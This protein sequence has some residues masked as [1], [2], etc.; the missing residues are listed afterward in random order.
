[1]KPK[2]PTSVSTRRTHSPQTEHTIDKRGTV[3]GFLI[4]ITWIFFLWYPLAAALESED[5]I[6]IPS[7]SLTAIFLLLY[8]AS[9]AVSFKN[10]LHIKKSVSIGAVVLLV[11]GVAITLVQFYLLG[12]ISVT[13]IVYLVPMSVFSLPQPWNFYVGMLATIT[14]WIP[15]FITDIGLISV[16]FS[17]LGTYV[18]VSASIFFENTRLKKQEIVAESATLKERERVARDVHDVLGHTLTAIALKS[19]LA[20]ELIE[21]DPARAKNEIDAIYEL[22]RQAIA[23]VR[24][25]VS[26]LRVRQLVHELDSINTIAA[27]AG[28]ALAVEGSP[29]EVEP[30]ARIL[31]AWALREAATNTIRHASATRITVELTNDSIVIRDDGIGIGSRR[32][33]NGLTGLRQRVEDAGASISVTDSHPGTE[34]RINL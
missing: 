13:F 7:I 33:G 10:N 16:G 18:F 11:S 3:V 29:D 23:E 5:S 22:S 24:A 1:M 28:I 14:T 26:G 21:K 19:E 8:I 34:V 15:A 30:S 32:F 17:A 12:A 20:G 31:F 6:K 4:G 9:L 27:D 2:T 25:T